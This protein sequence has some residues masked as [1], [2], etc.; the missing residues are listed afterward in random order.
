MTPTPNRVENNDSDLAIL[1][2]ALCILLAGTKL[3]AAIFGH[4]LVMVADAAESCLDLL[5]AAVLW[6]SLTYASRSPD[7]NHPYGHGKAESVGSLLLGGM[8]LLVVV[9]VTIRSL[10]ALLLPSGDGPRAWTLII[11]ALV[12]LMKEGMYRFFRHRAE[13][14]RSP[15]LMAHALE[16]RGDALTSA[17][18]F[19]G[20]SLAVVGG[21]N[22]YWADPVAA[23]AACIFICW[24]GYG[25]LRA[26]L[27]D[28]LDEEAEGRVK[29]EMK[30]EALGVKG[31]AGLDKCRL[32]RSGRWYYGELHVQV[33]ALLTV[34][35]G[36]EI[37]RLVRKKLVEADLGIA[38]VLVHIEPAPD[39]TQFRL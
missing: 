3:A 10:Q 26:S 25:I 17:A 8:V 6:L 33:D 12:L 31:V 27:A 19:V 4:S 18:G 38:D 30:E 29:D 36:H 22:W 11:V 21:R 24:N 39:S 9:G 16:H 15:I 7:E 2:F 23:L 1:S 5:G 32:R 28:L 34:E 37:A 20:I 13:L 14:S 35:Q